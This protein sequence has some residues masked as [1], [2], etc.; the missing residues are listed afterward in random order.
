MTPSSVSQL[1]LNRRGLLKGASILGAGLVIGFPIAP[2][3]VFAQT[4]APIPKNFPPAGYM[5]IA[6]DDSITVISKHTEMGQGIYTG[7][8]TMVADELD[9]D[10]SKVRVVSAPVNLELYAHFM[11]PGMQGTGG[12]MSTPNSWIQYRTVG[13]TARAMLVNAAANAWQ[14]PKDEITVTN[15]IISHHSSGRSA[16]FGRFAEAA[17]KLTPPT[18]VPL[19]MPNQFTLIGNELPKVDSYAKCTGTAEYTID[20]RRPNMVVAMVER[21]PRF[22]GKLDSFDASAARD[23]K[24]VVDVFEIP[25]GVAVL[26]N[27]THV[28]RKA[29]EALRMKW[30]DSTAEMRGAEDIIDDYLAMT[31]RPGAVFEKKGDSQTA[32]KSAAKVVEADYIFP[33]LAHACMEP[34][35]CTMEL[36]N[37]ECT[38]R[39]G[40]QMPSVERDRVA[41]ILG[42]PADKVYVE[43][44][45]AGGGFG[46]RANFVPELEA[47]AAHIVKATDGRYPVR[48][49]LTREDD[50]RAGY[51]RPLF[52]HRMR[53]VLDSNGNISAWENSLV[54]QSFVKGTFLDSMVQNGIDPIAIE[55]SA[56]LPYDIPNVSVD[57]HMAESGVPTLSWRS[58]S[59]THTGYSKET[60][61]DELL[62]AG[63]KDA[64]TGR[65][66]LMSDERAKKVVMAAAEH[67]SWGK[68]LPRG[69][70]H[71]FAYVESFNTRVAEVAE[72][73]L[74]TSGVP[75]VH[76]VTVAVDCGTAINPNIIRAQVESAIAMGL[77]AALY[78]EV[79]IKK[80]IVQTQNFDTYRI[81]RM[82]QMPTIDVH[83][84]PSNE[85]PT[86]IGEPGLPP[87]APAVAN[88]VYKLTGKRIRRLPFDRTV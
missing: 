24:G 4:G 82:N 42:L 67:V 26:A 77:T 6:P 22:G 14:V 18:D 58:V 3:G 49:Q 43:N 64:V 12:S 32:K 25:E 36:K 21:S 37:G 55:G 73:S 9:A 71:G 19:K 70:A 16:T 78:G 34:L 60:F 8:A 17:A 31:A 23:I 63:G 75:R 30:D 54:G 80:G 11:L 65:L 7:L 52:V 2:R 5:H 47:M 76:K 10:W 79:K 59:N 41:G 61:I 69:R 20:V 88:A 72:V 46:R 66:A 33:Y 68:S 51:Y 39:S 85:S 44:L 35:D 50:T 87:I 40:T 53:A 56:F 15:S 83:I 27:N 45:F 13:A 74:D 84:M 1:T 57:Y 86:G 48:L 62:E 29:R 81:L 38:I 28:A